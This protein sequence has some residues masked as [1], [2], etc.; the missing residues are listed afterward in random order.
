MGQ[1]WK[2]CFGKINGNTAASRKFSKEFDSPLSESTVYSLKK[3]YTAALESKKHSTAE[4]TDNT[5]LSSL[6]PTK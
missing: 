4:I 6:P 3:S 5:A 2:V 1:G